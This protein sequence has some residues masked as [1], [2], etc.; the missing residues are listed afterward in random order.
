MSEENKNIVPEG[1]VSWMISVSAYH[2]TKRL[3]A[4]GVLRI[5]L[6]KGATPSLKPYELDPNGEDI[7]DL[8]E[9]KFYTREEL[10]EKDYQ[11]TRVAINPVSDELGDN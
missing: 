5:N 4:L 9:N 2:P 7:Q 11:K 3:P 1:Q 6:P 8:D 10:E